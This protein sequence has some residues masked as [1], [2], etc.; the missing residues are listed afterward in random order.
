MTCLAALNAYHEIKPNSFFRRKLKKEEMKHAENT[1]VVLGFIKLKVLTKDTS[2]FFVILKMIEDN[3]NDV[4]GLVIGEK[5]ID[6]FEI[7]FENEKRS[8]DK[9]DVEIFIKIFIKK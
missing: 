2:D 1:L 4:F 5:E 9:K 3:V 8:I 7:I 6:E